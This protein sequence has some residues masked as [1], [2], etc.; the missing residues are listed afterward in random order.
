M[1]YRIEL[2]EYRTD[3]WIKLKTVKQ[4][5]AELKIYLCIIKRL[6]PGSRVRAFDDDTKKMVMVL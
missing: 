1:T 6:Y 5:M 3:E 2:S 4:S